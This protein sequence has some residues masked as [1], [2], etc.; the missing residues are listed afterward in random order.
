MEKQPITAHMRN[1]DLLKRRSYE[2]RLRK[3]IDLAGQDD[4]LDVRKP[5]KGS[6]PHL[7]S[8]FERVFKLHDPTIYTVSAI[9]KDTLVTL[10][11]FLVIPQDS[12]PN[13]VVV[14]NSPLKVKGADA[15]GDSIRAYTNCCFF[16]DLETGGALHVYEEGIQHSLYVDDGSIGT[17]GFGQSVIGTDTDMVFNGTHLNGGMDIGVM[18]AENIK[19]DMTGGAVGVDCAGKSI[20]GEGDHSPKAIF[21]FRGTDFPTSKPGMPPGGITKNDTLIDCGNCLG[22]IHEGVSVRHPIPSILFSPRKDSVIEELYYLTATLQQAGWE[23][24]EFTVID[25][26]SQPTYLIGDPGVPIT[27]NRQLILDHIAGDIR[28][29]GPIICTNEL[30]P[31]KA[32]SMAILG[33]RVSFAEIQTAG[34]VMFGD[35]SVVTIDG[36]SIG[37]GDMFAIHCRN[38]QAALTTVNVQNGAVLVV[39]DRDETKLTLDDCVVHG[40]IETLKNHCHQP[41]TIELVGDTVVEGIMSVDDIAP[42]A[43]RFAAVIRSGTLILTE[44]PRTERRGGK[45][46]FP[47]ATLFIGDRMFRPGDILEASEHLAINS[48]KKPGDASDLDLTLIDL[49]NAPEEAIEALTRLALAM[50]SGPDAKSLVQGQS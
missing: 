6:L 44:T 17:N 46:R 45:P 47:Q 3:A 27:L 33:S 18:V 15:N 10:D 30:L 25:G 5:A 32:N 13:S 14:F 36:G 7:S 42:S 4:V 24:P 49:E 2:G 35:K 28:F 16:G 19:V 41:T 11:D 38:A 39:G 23:H 31:K 50:N 48:L 43:S 40:A 21:I 29:R 37:G 20:S 9:E 12:D 34:G 8:F 1:R 22:S 26:E